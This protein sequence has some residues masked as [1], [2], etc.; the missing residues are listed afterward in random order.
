M[1][2]GKS[3]LLNGILFLKIKLFT[4]IIFKNLLHIV[5]HLKRR[6]YS[7]RDATKKAIY[8]FY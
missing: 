3:K 7:N 1:C 6:P 4:R 5:E 2:V 8:Y